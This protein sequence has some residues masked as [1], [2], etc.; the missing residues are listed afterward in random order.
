VETS[1]A[2]AFSCLEMPA[3]SPSR[4]GVPCVRG[5]LIFQISNLTWIKTG[6]RP[7]IERPP[8]PAIRRSGHRLAAFDPERV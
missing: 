7:K 4:T 8:F 5:D 1:S 2:T 3:Q 6:G